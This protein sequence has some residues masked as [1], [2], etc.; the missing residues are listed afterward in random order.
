MMA[1]RGERIL[2]ARPVFGRVDLFA[3]EH[4]IDLLAQV[5]CLGQFEQKVHGL[6]GNVVFE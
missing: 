4:G 6:V 5:A 2:W 3:A 1:L